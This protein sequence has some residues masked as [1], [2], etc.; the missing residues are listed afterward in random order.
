MGVL[1]NLKPQRKDGLGYCII[2]QNKGEQIAGR[3]DKKIRLNIAKTKAFE[4]NTKSNEANAW[5][6][7]IFATWLV[8]QL[9]GFELLTCQKLGDSSL[10]LFVGGRK[11]GCHWEVVKVSLGLK[12]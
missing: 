10:L 1:H 4:H 5:T 6:I 12:G 3:S 9:H 7:L 2:A 8:R 11:C